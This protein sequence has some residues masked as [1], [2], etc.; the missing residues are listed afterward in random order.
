MSNLSE[1]GK[2]SAVANIF[3]SAL[4]IIH[5]VYIKGKKNLS[6]SMQNKIQQK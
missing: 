6:H 3:L 4:E 1:G 2:K 5:W